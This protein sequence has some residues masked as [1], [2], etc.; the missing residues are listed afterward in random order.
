MTKRFALIALVVFLLAPLRAHAQQQPIR[1]NCGGPEYTDS[2]GHLWKADYGS[3]TGWVA[4]IPAI[5]NA[6]A[7][8]TLFQTARYHASAGLIYTFAV[9]DGTYHVNLYFSEN[10]DNG[11]AKV[12]SRIFNVKMQGNMVFPDLDIFAEAGSDAALVKG[13]DITV[14]NGKVTIEFDAIVNYAKIDAIEIL[15]GASGPQLSLMFRYPDGVPVTGTLSWAVS[16]SLLSFRG[17]ETLVNGRATCAMIANP[18]AIGISMQFTLKASLNDA[19]GHL[20]WNMNMAL[21]PAEVNLAAVQDSDLI[22][23]VQKVN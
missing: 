17:Q 4:A 23:T 6:T 3:N 15:P 8:P 21:N 20:L 13:S 5:V 11:N 2:N 1:V 12:G 7:D 22:V 16:S 9:P 18:S 10:Y 14:S 19:A